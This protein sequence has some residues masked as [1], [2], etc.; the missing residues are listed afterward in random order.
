MLGR[1]HA[2]GRHWRFVDSWPAAVGPASC[3]KGIF[4]LLWSLKNG[5]LEET[6]GASVCV[7]VVCV[8]EEKWPLVFGCVF[9]FFLVRKS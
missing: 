2:V 5:S 3:V 4:A 6:T 8:D 1:L 7:R 9:V